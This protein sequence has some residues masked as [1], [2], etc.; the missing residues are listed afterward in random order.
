[1]LP[2]CDAHLPRQPAGRL[3]A[4]YQGP[5]L[6][7]GLRVDLQF[8]SAGGEQG[9]GQPRAVAFLWQDQPGGHQNA[10]PTRGRR[11][12]R[13]AAVLAAS[14]RRSARAFRVDVLYELPQSPVDQEDG[15]GLRGAILEVR[16]VALRPD[17]AVRPHSLLEGARRMAETKQDHVVS[18]TV[19]SNG[20]TKATKA[21]YDRIEQLLSDDFQVVDVVSSAVTG[22]AGFISVTVVLTNRTHV[23]YA[24]SRGRKE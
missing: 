2:T 17:F 9:N 21:E 7:Q 24:M 13:A 22:A 10:V 16:R 4:V 11:A 3:R 23:V 12:G 18:Y 5:L 14:V 19:D 1:M 15:R 20:V 6:Q 8:H